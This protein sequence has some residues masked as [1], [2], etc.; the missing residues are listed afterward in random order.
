[1]TSDIRSYATAF[2]QILVVFLLIHCT[3][4]PL[5]AG[6]L[7]KHR[8][9]AGLELFPAMLAADSGI[10]EKQTPDG[11]LLLLLVYR[12]RKAE[13]EEMAEFLS[14]INTIRGISVKVDITPYSRIEAYENTRVAGIFLTQKE[15]GALFRIIHYG[16]KHRVIVFSPFA[17]DIERGVSGGILISDIIQPY[18]NMESLDRSTIALKPFFMKVAERYEP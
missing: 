4:L 18:V 3:L 14:S 7:V 16:E 13:A 17:G 15:P 11:R 12:D 5:S 8:I 1:M 2:F 6:E 9:R 10:G